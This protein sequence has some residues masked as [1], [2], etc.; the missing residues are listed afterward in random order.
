MRY[1]LLGRSGLRVSEVGLGAMTFSDRGLSWGAA[2]DEAR[3][4]FEAFARAG[5]T[6][7]DTANIYGDE[8][9]GDEGSSERVLADVLAADREHFVL[10]TKYTSSNTTD[11]SRSGN[12]FKAM[13][14]SVDAS[15]RALRTDHIDVLWLHTWDGTTPVDEVLR[16]AQQLVNAGK[17]LYFGLSDT[18]AWVVSQAVATAEA[19]G[20]T[21]PI[22]IQVEYSLAERTPERELLPMAESLDLGVAAWGP[23]AAGLLTGKYTRS[24]NGERRSATHRFADERFTAVAG[25]ADEHRLA[26]AAAVDRVAGEL[27]RPSAHVALAW[28]RQRPGVVIPILGARRRDQLE[29]N[30]AGLDLVLDDQHAQT[31]EAAGAPSLGFPQA[32][33]A[34]GTVR[35]YSTSGHYDR[36]VN[37]HAH[38][39][40]EFAVR[41]EL[42]GLGR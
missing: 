9:G 7:V 23:L 34:S 25:E 27:G 22:A 15:L 31:L 37:H 38:H 21:P 19:R 41:G 18:P 2:P 42:P 26:V 36:L 1:R 16:G 35:R 12:S 6:Y 39:Y 30:L 13:R 3:A 5:G 4:T 17:I 28:L 14:E 8:V 20:T 33:L 11:V 32:F 29:E 24:G 40:A 10:A